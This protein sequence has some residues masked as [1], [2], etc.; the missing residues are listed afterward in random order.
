[1]RWLVA[2]ALTYRVVV[3]VLAAVLIVVG[4]RIAQDAPFDV[5]P[6]FAPTLVEIQ[7]EAPGLSTPEVENLV[8]IPIE[9]VINGI[10]FLK[11]IRSKSVLGLSS[12]VLIFEDGTDLWR[13]RQVVQERLGAITSVLPTVASIPTVLP[14]LSATSRMLKIGISS[15]TLS[16]LELSLLAVHTIRPRLM[17]V[18]GVAN[19][20]IW[21]QQDRQ[22][23]A[24]VEPERLRAAGVTLDEL[25]TSGERALLVGAGGFVDTANQRLSVLHE[26]ATQ[27]PEELAS[28][29]VAYRNGAAIRMGDV[30]EVAYGHQAMI[31]DAIINDGPGLLL[32]V[33]KQP[34]GNTF[35][36]THEVEAALA[37]LAPGLVGVEVDSTI[38]RPATFIQMSLDNLSKALLF[39]IVL[40]V[41][42]LSAFLY[43]WRTAAISAVAIPLSLLTAAVVLYYRGGTINTMVLAGLIIAL[44]EVVDDAIIDVENIVRRLRLEADAPSPRPAY[45]VVLEASMEV[46]SAVVYG[47]LIVVLVFLPVFFL[48]GLSGAFF[49][50]LAFSYV[51][52]IMASLA[53]ALTVTPALSLMLLPGHVAAKNEAPLVRWLKRVYR[54]LLPRLLARRRLALPAVV[55]V[56]GLSAATVPFLGEE[57]LPDFKEY[58]FLMHWVEKPGTSLDAM[59]RITVRASRELRS[60]PGVRNFGAHIGRAEVADEVVGPNFTE[61]WISLDPEADYAAALGRIQEVVAGYPG[62]YRDVLTYLKERIKEVLTG[63]SATLVV[64]VYGPDLEGLRNHAARV[65]AA[66]AAVPGLADLHV[67]QQEDVAQIVVRPRADALARYGLTPGAVR[68]AAT[69]LIKG[70]KIGEA[71]EGQMTFDVVVWGVESIRDDLEDIGQLRVDTAGGGQVPLADLADIRVQSS[72]NTILREGS[73][74]RIDISSNVTG[75]DLGSVARDVEAAVGGVAFERGYHPE[76][77]G[78]YAE[79]RAARNR[80]LALALLS[81]IGI[82][83]ILHA[84]FGS[85]RVASLVFVSLPFA[86]SGGVVAVILAGGVL[87]LGSLVGFVTVLGIAARNGIMLVSHY[88]HLEHEEGMVFGPELILRGAEERLAPILMTALTTMLAL[89]PIVVG[90]NLP[91]QEI[92]HPMALVIV[93]GLV[94]STLLTLLVVPVLYSLYGDAGDLNV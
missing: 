6:E 35:E 42:V 5:F 33:E 77:L 58:D 36:V 72:P 11:T 50:P 70:R 23:Q 63:A 75:R 87:S 32:I 83:L 8:T 56:I 19:V 27:T 78:E 44:G 81:A 49:R 17:S 60:I 29:V 20:A 28:V 37:A 48:G 94:T 45:R 10:S 25:V 57:F 3:V 22:V 92:E 46:R 52:A 76:F 39:G 30:A 13:A 24:L 86:L 61:L 65:Q 51:L 7:T 69:T 43:E 62:L 38:F 88:R 47:S 89:V 41:I 55:A 40:V 34:W 82:F 84:D 90:G 85:V 53:V 80:L 1:M 66:M 2:T 93:G 16:Q 12:V 91:G 4:I 74:R 73:S 14:P 9:N 67:E 79:Q 15:P 18:P 21:G 68:G 64:R 54:R 71:Y 59:R 26:Q 31:G